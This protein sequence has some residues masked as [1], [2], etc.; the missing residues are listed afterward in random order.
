[1]NKIIEFTAGNLAFDPQDIE[2]MS[3]AL[4][5]VCKALNISANTTA[6]E[7]VA[8]RIL[9]LAR[10]GERNPAALQDRVLTESTSGS[11]C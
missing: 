3:L 5:E 6:R 7:L 9:E 11:G 2:A 10:H 4:D 8:L 1:M